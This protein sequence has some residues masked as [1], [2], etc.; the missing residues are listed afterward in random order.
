MFRRTPPALDCLAAMRALGEPSRL[1]IVRQLLAKP[2]A[3][4]ELC[5]ALGLT[6]YNT[7]RHLSVLKA[8]GLVEVEK[9]A[10]QRIY[11][12][13]AHFKTKFTKNDRVLDLGCCQFD[14]NQLPE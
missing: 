12:L 2:H 5:E 11:A 1:R 9:L 3:V 4:N 14:F 13:A 6:A 10:Q 8:A 7:S